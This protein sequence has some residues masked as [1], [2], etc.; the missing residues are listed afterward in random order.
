[1][2][3]LK[4]YVQGP[5]AEEAEMSEPAT[6]DSAAGAVSKAEPQALDERIAYLIERAASGDHASLR[7]VQALLAE[8]KLGQALVDTVGSPAVWLRQRLISDASGENVFAQDAIRRKLD[9]IQAELEG[10]SPTPVE[11]LLA[12][13][14]TL[15]W[16]MAS[17][18]ES[19]FTNADGWPEHQAKLQQLKIDRAHARFLSAVRTLA[20]VRKLAVPAL[21]VNIAKNQ[22][23]VARGRIMSGAFEGE[24]PS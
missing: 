1:M 3:T 16:F 7:T 24:R 22:V 6:Q 5:V 19:V 18:H 20:Q 14:A 23:N 15:C 9:S 11:R 17:W 2:D 4:V 8:G 12:E 10:E 13:Q 21:Q